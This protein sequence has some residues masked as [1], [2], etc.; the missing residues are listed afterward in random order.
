MVRE[1]WTLICSSIMGKS[2]GLCLS[3]LICHM[4]FTI[5]PSPR[6]CCENYIKSSRRHR[7][8]LSTPQYGLSPI[9]NFSLW[10]GLLYQWMSQW[11]RMTHRL[12]ECWRWLRS[13]SYLKKRKVCMCRKMSDIENRLVAAKREGIGWTERVGLVDTKYYIYNR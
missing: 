11:E 9:G 2:L 4:G 3:A 13:H 6:I 12:K 8:K 7:T 5:V 10:K 1:V